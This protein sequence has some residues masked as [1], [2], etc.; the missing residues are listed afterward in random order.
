[1]AASGAK[2]L[3]ERIADTIYD[4]IMI[5][6]AFSAGDKLP[7]ENE[8]AELL[9]VSRTTV[10]EAIKILAAQGIV[11]V[12]RGKGTFI[13]NDIPPLRE[14][15]VTAMERMKVRL[16]DLYE[17]RLM[18]EPQAIRLACERATDEELSSIVEQG[19]TIER[20]MHK[21]GDW[22][23][24][25]QDFHEMIA[26]ASHNEFIIQLFPIINSAVHDAMQVAENT[27]ELKKVVLIDNERILDFLTM[28]DGEGAFSA[29]DIHIRHM[30]NALKLKN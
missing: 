28:R 2:S 16:S 26:A 29:M 13:E 22:P 12:R 17:I 19:A 25:D 10:R 30:I 15:S 7:N 18:F 20:L 6:K 27:D 8:L 5:E 1:M 3:S 21:N 11:V 24:A 4:K 14:Y 9:G 23:D